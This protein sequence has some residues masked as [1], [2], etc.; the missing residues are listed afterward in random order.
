MIILISILTISFFRDE[1]VKK[2]VNMRAIG[3]FG[4]DNSHDKYNP[5]GLVSTNNRAKRAF[6]GEWLK[7][8]IEKAN[9]QLE[10]KEM[11]KTCQY[12]S[13]LPLLLKVTKVVCN[14][15]LTNYN[16]PCGCIDLELSRD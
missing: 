6:I 4:S 12:F 5:F 15:V 9:A 11:G 14:S 13:I 16:T 10:D 8:G 7:T 3:G 1:L 2:F